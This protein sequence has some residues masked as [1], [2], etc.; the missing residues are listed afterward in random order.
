MKSAFPWILT[1]LGAF[2]AFM[3][4]LNTT[5]MDYYENGSLTPVAGDPSPDP[6]FRLLASEEVRHSCSICGDCVHP[7]EIVENRRTLSLRDRDG[8]YKLFWAADETYYF[9]ELQHL[10]ANYENRTADNPS[11]SWTITGRILPSVHKGC[12]AH[13]CG[14]VNPGFTLTYSLVVRE[15]PITPNPGGSLYH[16]LTYPYSGNKLPP[17]LNFGWE[18][19]T[20]HYPQPVPCPCGTP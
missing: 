8:W 6:A 13:E 16:A 11:G 9:E 10:A 20:A 2:V 5:E 7:V 4:Y 12:P 14:P 17:S 18:L 1:A 19:Q 15:S 3:L